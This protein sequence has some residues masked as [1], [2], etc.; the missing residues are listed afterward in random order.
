MDSPEGKLET[1]NDVLYRT[2]MMTNNMKPN[3]EDAYKL[4]HEATIT[5]SRMEAN[6]IRIDTD[7]LDRTINQV[8]GEIKEKEE[9]LH[10][11]EPYKLWRKRFKHKTNIDSNQQ[12][13][14]VLY[15]EM[16]YEPVGYTEKGNVP[17]TDEAALQGIDLQFIKDYFAV[18][19]LKKAVGTYLKG[20][21][22][23]VYN[24]LLHAGY[25]LAGGLSGE[26][27]D[28][29]GAMSYRGSSSMPNFQNIPIRNP[30]IGKM[31]RQAFI[32]RK[33]R[34]IVERDFSG[35]EVRVFACFTK[36]KKLIHYVKTGAGNMHRD[37][38]YQI[39]KVT[40]E[41]YERHGDYYK[42]TIRDSSKNQFV[43]PEFYG[44]VYFQCAPPIWE[45]V[46]RRDFRYGT[47]GPSMYDHLRKKGIAELGECDP[48]HIHAHG[49]K[50]G[51]F[52]HHLKQVEKELWGPDFFLESAKYRRK[53]YDE[54]LEKGYFD[55]FT[56][57]RCTGHYRRNQVTNFPV[58]GPAFHCL[59]WTM[60]ET[61]KEIDRRGMDTLL[62]GQIHDSLLADVPED[63]LQEYLDITEEIA[64]RRLPAAWD[65]II[66][67]IEVEAEVTPLRGNWY[68]KA[69][70]RNKN[71][72]WQ[73][74]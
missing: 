42:K 61:Q 63:E 43:F 6:G 29:G 11:A 69:E 44:S 53:F 21:K 62:I 57:F 7:Y 64:T 41:H 46:E 15:E 34:R 22:R 2:K 24:G 25:N 27:D 38:S 20:I 19:K 12:L 67:P 18:K 28:K 60:I 31:I 66:V 40:P 49:T 30:V 26:E 35:V 58:Q 32:P 52:V 33:G 50:E 3:R 47:D 73:A 10:R 65:W 59:V 23:E 72:V 74:A 8:E 39:F 71:G 1:R 14:A 5:L 36:D 13:A 17:R 4:F 48:D 37:M 51:T 55:L 54:Y 56:G 9:A 68:E 45:A 70:W 16:G